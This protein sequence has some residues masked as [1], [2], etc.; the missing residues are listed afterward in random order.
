VN[1]VMNLWVAQNEGNFLASQD[2]LCSMGLV[3][4]V[5][6]MVQFF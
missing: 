6:S 3:E 5:S 2:G 1:A 4:F